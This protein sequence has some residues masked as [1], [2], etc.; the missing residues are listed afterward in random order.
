MTIELKK[1]LDFI[2]TEDPDLV[3]KE[4][5]EKWSEHLKYSKGIDHCL[6]SPDIKVKHCAIGPSLDS[7][8]LPLIAELIIE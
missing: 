5:S 8:H 3:I 2:D 6:V 7:D 4:V 1:I